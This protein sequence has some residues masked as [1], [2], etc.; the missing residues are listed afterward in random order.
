MVSNVMRI[1]FISHGKFT[2]ITPYLNY[3]S[4][5]GHDV[6]FIRLAD[7]PIVDGV[8]TFD[9]FKGFPSFFPG[10]FSY[11]FASL[12]ARRIIQKLKPDII[13][14][15]FATSGGVAAYISGFRPY[16]I[17]A[18][19]TDILGY[20]RRKIWRHILSGILKRASRIIVVSDQ[21]REICEK[22]IGSKNRVCVVNVGI[23][24]KKFKPLEDINKYHGG[25]IRLISTRRMEPIYNPGVIIDALKILADKNIDFR[26]TFVGG[27]PLEEQMEQKANSLGLRDFIDFMGQ[28]PNRQLP[29]IL[30]ENH[31]YLSASIWDGSSLSLMESMSVGLFP[32]VSDIEANRVWIN[33]GN[34]GLLFD[35]SCPEKLACSI[36]QF[37][38]WP[39]KSEFQEIN[40]SLVCDIGDHYKNMCVFEKILESIVETHE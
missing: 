20:H 40:R 17:T 9:A 15:H 31:V 19:G 37:L 5:Q 1:I 36:E 33:S 14:A 34:N 35:V 7:G 30:A 18:H 6:I 38:T 23:D 10:K 32:V 39:G 12:K 24:T 29:Q 2:H 13:N 21:L 22:L 4:S 11:V 3:F 28:V 27:G 26:M 8:E 25:P 16:V